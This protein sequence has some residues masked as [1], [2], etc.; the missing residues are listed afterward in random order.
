MHL[1]KGFEDLSS[2]SARNMSG[3]V[4]YVGF[5]QAPAP[6]FW[7]SRE[8]S[9]SYVFFS[10]ILCSELSSLSSFAETMIFLFIELKLREQQNTCMI[11][12]AIE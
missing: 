2:Y 9:P 10:H 8:I 1:G 4:T 5:V 3:M 7:E 11:S 12:C 6:E